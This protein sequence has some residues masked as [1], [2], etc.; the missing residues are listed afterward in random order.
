M[1]TSPPS[2]GRLESS[3]RS[4]GLA[5]ISEGYSCICA[6]LATRLAVRSEAHGVVLSNDGITLGLYAEGVPALR[7]TLTSESSLRVS[8]SLCGSTLHKGGCTAPGFAVICLGN[9]CGYCTWQSEVA[10][11][12]HGP[13]L[14]SLLHVLAP[15]ICCEQ[16]DRSLPNGRTICR[17]PSKY[18]K[19]N[20]RDCRATRSLAPTPHL[21]SHPNPITIPDLHQIPHRS[22]QSSRTS[23]ADIYRKEPTGNSDFDVWCPS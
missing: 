5:C 16:S 13:S 15:L 3:S 1:D 11:P 14:A 20:I 12:K 23:F 17:L 18:N 8:C 9:V 6:I 21:N 19:Y 10:G 22:P 4:Q 7:L 2:C